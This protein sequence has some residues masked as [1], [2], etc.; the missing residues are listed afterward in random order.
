MPLACHASMP[1]ASPVIM[2]CG[3]HPCPLP[4]PCHQ[5]VG[6]LGEQEAKVRKQLA[7]RAHVLKGALLEAQCS[8]RNGS[9]H[10]RTHRVEVRGGWE[11]GTGWR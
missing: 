11:R 8:V 5:A 9:A 1:P 10:A 3:A 6:A 2:T 7:T 4:P